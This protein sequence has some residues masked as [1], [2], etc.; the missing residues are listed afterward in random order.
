MQIRSE[1]PTDLAGI[2][3]VN[4]AAFGT[5]TEADLV[6][7]LRV[8]AS[9]I[10]SLVAEERGSIVGHIL[11]SPVTLSSDPD[12]PLMALAPM[13][14]LPAWQR[15]GVGSGLVRAGL[16]ACRQLPARAVVVVGHAGYYPRFGFVPASGYGI[17]S[18]FDVPA[19]AFMVLELQPGALATRRGT[20]RYHPAFSSI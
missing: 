17:T 12:L 10:I 7:R 11:F 8:E 5:A 2:R 14:V 9:P 6:D 15:R 13:A 19:D 18:E 1:Q 16:E 20:I 4:E 3:A